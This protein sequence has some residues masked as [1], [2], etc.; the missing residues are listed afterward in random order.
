MSKLI[1]N[2]SVKTKWY[3]NK[4]YIY[5]PTCLILTATN[6]CEITDPKQK[7]SCWMKLIDLMLYKSTKP[8]QPQSFSKHLHSHLIDPPESL[9]DLQISLSKTLEIVATLV[10]AVADT[11]NKRVQKIK[12]V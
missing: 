3:T 12:E 11:A 4:K 7:I 1:T 9:K 2:D 6:K 8:A 10:T 5:K